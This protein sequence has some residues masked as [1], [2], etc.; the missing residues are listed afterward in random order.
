MPEGREEEW[1]TIVGFPLY[2]I[3]AFGSV[4]N[5]EKGAKATL[6][7]LP[8]GYIRVQ[9]YTSDK[10]T[11]SPIRVHKCMLLSWVGPPPSP[12]HTPD[13]IDGD[14]SNNA[15]ENLRWASK[16]EQRAN[17]KAHVAQSSRGVIRTGADGAMAY[18][19]VKAAA[20]ANDYSEG[21]IWGAINAGYTTR[22]GFTF[23]YSPHDTIPG[24]VWQKIDG[25]AVDRYVSSAG[26]ILNRDGSVTKGWLRMGYPTIEVNGLG[27][28][29]VH[30]LVAT[31]FVPNP[32]PEKFD[33][34][35][36]INHD[37]QDNRAENLEWTDASGNAQAAIRAGAIKTK[38]VFQFDLSGTFIQKHDSTRK[39][40]EVVGGKKKAIAACACGAQATSGGFLWSYTPP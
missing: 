26:R 1:R 13:H 22:E 3:D 30:R 15:L 28:Q 16:A 20:E 2:A 4:F 40:E 17:Q 27:K 39:A 38:P 24:E 29:S 8:G 14:P 31:A 7:R 25:A 9:L 12:L 5:K 32:S 23:A 33:I 19:S 11:A 6:A 18:P 36:H 21:R 34:V 35:N 10:R 37:R